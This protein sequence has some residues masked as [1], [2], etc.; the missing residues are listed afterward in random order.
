NNLKLCQGKFRLDMRKNFFTERGIRHWNGL[1]RSVV[2][3]P[4]L[5]IFK[6]RVDIV[7][8]DLV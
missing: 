5:E 6:S 3:S 7:R 2:E 4:F 8:R 1:P